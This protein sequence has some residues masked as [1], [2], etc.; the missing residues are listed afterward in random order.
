MTW[1]ETRVLVVG[2]VMLDRWIYMRKTK[3]SPEAPV[4]I[5]VQQEY[6]AEIGGAGNAFRH[7]R[8]LSRAEHSL[9]GVR[10]QDPSGVE[11]ASLGSSNVENINIIIDSGRKTTVKE[12]F[13]IDGEPI[14]R[15]DNEDV[16]PLSQEIEN[17]VV[18]EISNRLEHF[19][20]LLLSDYAKG[21][22]SKSLI[23]NLLHLAKTK[24]VPIVTDPGLGRLALFA[25]CDVIKPNAKEWQDFVLSHRN[26]SEALNWLFSRGTKFVIVT[27]GKHGVTLFSNSKTLS[28][29]P[30]RE[31]S[32]VDVTGAGDSVAAAISLIIGSG[33]RLI[34]N[35]GI[36]NSVGGLTV[37]QN[38]TVLPKL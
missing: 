31:I 13:F 23:T 20:V 35:L 6:F 5:V 27:T 28:V 26:K 36:L 12:R 11:V 24:N 4:P 14:F 2:D 15:R 25:G 10:G 37:G 3:L 18:F 9:I 21:M 16:M 19:K 17:K 22:L 30:I 38:R 34:E 7:L 29:P 1:N 33:E 8:N 32:A